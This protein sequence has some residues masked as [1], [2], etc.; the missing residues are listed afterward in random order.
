MEAGWHSV[1]HPD[2]LGVV[3]TEVR[4][5]L[6]EDASTVGCGLFWGSSRGTQTLVFCARSERPAFE[7]LRRKASRATATRLCCAP[8]RSL[9]R[10]STST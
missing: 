9:R 8:S 5:Y 4:R 6:R 1:R 10:G 2:P 7:S 3:L